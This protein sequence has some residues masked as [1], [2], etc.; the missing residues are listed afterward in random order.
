MSGHVMRQAGS[1][2]ALVF[3]HG[4]TMD[5]SIFAG[6]FDRLSDRFTCM[7]PDLPGHGQAADLSADIETGAS[8][9][10]DILAPLHH[11]GCAVTLIGWSMGAAVAWRYFADFGG[12]GV[13]RLI[14]VD[15][16]PKIVNE[17]DWTRGLKRQ[18]RAAIEINS[19]RFQD[20]W[21]GSAATLAAGMFA[22]DVPAALAEDARARIAATPS[23][24]MN[25]MWQ[26]LVEM[27]MRKAIPALSVPYLV[28]HGARSRVYPASAA[29]WL[30]QSAQ[31]ARPQA[32]AASGHSPHLE[33]PDAF[34]QVV[35]TFAQGG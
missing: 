26:S 3:L 16:S 34:A 11:A 18:T 25:A 4:W 10:H 6:Q 21:T 28:A 19:R 7:A 24:P 27:D 33:E 29:D 9:L 17:H 31:N 32:F 1:G 35:G 22:P 20:D 12:L 13:A 14:S 15:M 5:S 8:V 23:Q 2:P 30:V